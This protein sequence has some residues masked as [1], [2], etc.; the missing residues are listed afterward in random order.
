MTNQETSLFTQQTQTRNDSEMSTSYSP[1]LQNWQKYIPGGRD[2][3]YLSFLSKSDPTFS[4]FVGEKS[5]SFNFY[6]LLILS[7]HFLS[8]MKKENYSKT[9]DIPDTF[10]SFMLFQR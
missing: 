2:F 7:T 10:K 8:Q 1:S 6:Q 9:I 4:I 5:F 3:H